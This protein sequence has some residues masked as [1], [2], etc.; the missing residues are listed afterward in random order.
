MKRLI[1]IKTE[2]LSALV[3]PFKDFPVSEIMP[4]FTAPDEF[5]RF[6][7]TFEK[8]RDSIAPELQSDFD[9]LEISQLTQLVNQW[10]ENETTDI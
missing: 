8:L 5:Q 4:I 2:G 7:L 1:E 6:G 9:L 10:F 3:T